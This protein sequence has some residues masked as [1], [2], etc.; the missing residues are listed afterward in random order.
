[1]V[2]EGFCRPPGQELSRHVDQHHDVCIEGPGKRGSG[3]P[4]RLVIGC[5]RRQTDI[6]MGVGRQQA[7]QVAD[8][9]RRTARYHQDTPAAVQDLGRRQHRVVLA[10][11]FPRLCRDRHPV[12][13]PSRPDRP[14]GEDG[15]LLAV[16]KIHRLCSHDGPGLGHG[17]PAP[18]PTQ[19]AC[20][21]DH[22]QR[23]VLIH[24]AQRV[25]HGRCQ[26]DVDS[27]LRVADPNGVERHPQFPGGPFGPAAQV[28]PAVR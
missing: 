15:L 6:Q 14:Q 20:L 17:Q 26:R 16:G 25:Q 28:M 12:V 23:H 2:R 8:I 22:R 9:S 11:R 27:R 13:V 4:L 19:A 3:S 1:M 5:R 24:V 7:T 21:Q 10:R 18:F